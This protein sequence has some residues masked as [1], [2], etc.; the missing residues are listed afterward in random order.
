VKSL[1]N[2]LI[3]I[4]DRTTDRQGDAILAKDVYVNDYTRVTHDFNIMKP[5][6]RATI[7]RE[8]NNFFADLEILDDFDAGGLYPCVGGSRKQNGV[9]EIFEVALCSYP[10]ADSR[11]RPIGDVLS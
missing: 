8:G 4:A 1:K 2:I 7:R 9:N 10:N 11:I 5:V 3:L 6:G